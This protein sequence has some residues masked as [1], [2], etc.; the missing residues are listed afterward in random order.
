MTELELLKS[1]ITKLK[2]ELEPLLGAD[3]DKFI[4]IA[5]NF[6]EGKPKLLAASRPS[7]F[8]EIIKAAQQ[9]L[10]LDGQEASLVPFKETVK[11]MVGYKG[12]LKMVRNSGELA[13]INAMVVYEKEP[14]EFFIDEKGEHVKHTPMLGKERGKPVMTYCIARIKGGNE[15]YIEVMSEDEVQSC[16][17]VSRAGDDS[18]WNGPFADEMR[19][20]TVIRRISKR[21]PMST[22]LNMA[23]NDEEF[24]EPTPADPVEP[25]TTSTRLEQAVVATPAP[26]PEPLLEHPDA[27]KMELALS[28]TVRGFIEAVGAKP[29]DKGG[30]RYWVKIA[31]VFYGTF[32]ETEYKKCEDLFNKK[33]PVI[34][35]YVTKQTKGKPPV[36]FNDLLSIMADVKEDGPNDNDVPI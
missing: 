6:L 16:R 34:I 24:E 29:M 10:F 7:L 12:I 13:S 21:L 19:K 15:P 3:T 20:K 31:G 11:L 14:F 4:Q 23:I 22:D 1:S 32:S 5:C 35:I 2:P 30:F 27:K 33:V 36:N 18:P 8:A 17:K 28:Q 9:R 25:K 26:T